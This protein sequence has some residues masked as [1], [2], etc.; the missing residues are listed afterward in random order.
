MLKHQ[1]SIHS[2]IE[3]ENIQAFILIQHYFTG[4]AVSLIRDAQFISMEEIDPYLHWFICT[5]LP[6]QVLTTPE[7]G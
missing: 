6:L 7:S 1:L 5:K 4:K 2:T 3:Y